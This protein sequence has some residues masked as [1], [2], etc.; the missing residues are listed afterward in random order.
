MEV[1]AQAKL[2]LTLD[3]I[4]KRPDGY[5]DLRMI[6]QS[7]A[8]LHSTTQHRGRGGRGVSNS[9]LPSARAVPPMTQ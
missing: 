9:P 7:V 5:H 3:V 1:Q 4:G 2:N 6:M 8:L